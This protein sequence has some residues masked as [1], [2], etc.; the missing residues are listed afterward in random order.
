MSQSRERI[1]LVLGPLLAL[2]WVITPPL[3]GMAEATSQAGA[4]VFHLKAALGV[5]FWVAT[6]WITECVP[7]GLAGL[8]PALIFPAIGLVTW[9]KALSSFTSPIIWIFMGGF[10]LAKAFQVWG[11]DKRIAIKLSSLYKGS[12]PALAAFFTACLPVF[13]LTMTGSITASTSIT[14]PIVLAYLTTLGFKKGSRYGE[15]TMLALGEAATAGAMFL[16]ISTPPNLIAK[17]AIEEAL[18]GFTITF[19]DWIIVGTPHALIGLLLTWFLTFMLIKPEIKELSIEKRREL[20]GKVELGPM[21]KEEKVVFAVFVL[22][23]ILWTIPGL[24]LIYST[25]NPGIEWLS[26]LL[27]SILPEAAPAVLAILLLGLIKVENRPLLSWKDIEEG[28]DWNVVF[29]FG[30]GI[31]LGAGLQSAGFAKWISELIVSQKIFEINIYTLSIISAVLAFIITY[32]ASNTASAL[33]ACPLVAAMAVGAGI[34]PV[35]P[36]IIAG[37]AAS[38]SSALPSTTPPMAIVYGSRYI[39]LWNMFKVGMICD[40]IRLIILIIVGPPLAVYLC[41]LKGLPLT[42]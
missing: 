16:L 7:L 22:T 21:S 30:G 12:N 36:V 41:Q 20:L 38:I 4:T 24:V 18:P 3:P 13:I 9:K 1:G 6:W 27:K 8:I 25:I 37:L 19:L 14:Y 11:L 15:A 34:N 40:I 2:L 42:L 31:I 10:V 5:L 23:L 33:I 17:S 29:L 26:S 28:I 32:P 39:K 35:P